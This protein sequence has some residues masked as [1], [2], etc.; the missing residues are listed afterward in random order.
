M[1]RKRS[2]TRTAGR[3]AGAPARTTSSRRTER[4]PAAAAVEEG[5]IGIE[6][7]VG[8]ATTAT[9]LVAFLLLDYTLGKFLGSGMFF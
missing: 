3:T 8:I 6:G 5:G 4:G 2:T 1:A 7:G 9:L